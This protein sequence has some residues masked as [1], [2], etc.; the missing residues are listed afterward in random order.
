MGRPDDIT[1]LREMLAEI[2]RKLDTVI[3]QP[4]P[5]WMTVAEY[6]DISNVT[7]RTD[8]DKGQS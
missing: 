8:R 4:R 2:N 5:E 3:M 7:P 6:A 1:E